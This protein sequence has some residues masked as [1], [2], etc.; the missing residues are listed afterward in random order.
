MI[1]LPEGVKNKNED[2][3]K[4]FSGINCDFNKELLSKLRI[5]ARQQ[6]VGEQQAILL[7]KERCRQSATQLATRR[8]RI[9]NM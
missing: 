6:L 5:L 7:H 9:E 8:D 2:Y 4:Q 3:L 1:I